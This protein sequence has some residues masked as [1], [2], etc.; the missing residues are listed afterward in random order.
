MPEIILFN[1]TLPSTKMWW[2]A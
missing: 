1:Q 2:C